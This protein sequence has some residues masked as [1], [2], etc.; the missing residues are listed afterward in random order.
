M[1]GLVFEGPLERFWTEATA[2]D[3]DLVE[4]LRSY[5]IQMTQVGGSFY[6]GDEVRLLECEASSEGYDA[7]LGRY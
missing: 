2:P 6:S 1:P 5:L 3:P 4:R 7:A